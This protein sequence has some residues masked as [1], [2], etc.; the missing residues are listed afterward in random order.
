M[1]IKKKPKNEDDVNIRHYDKLVELGHTLYCAWQA[2][3]HGDCAML[4]HIK[5]ISSTVQYVWSEVDNIVKEQSGT[6][7]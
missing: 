2:L 4:N 1:I 3:E 5:S 7:E 6:K